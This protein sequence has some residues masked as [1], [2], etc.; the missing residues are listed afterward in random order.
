MAQL[1]H[2]TLTG[3]VRKEAQKSAVGQRNWAYSEVNLKQAKL[4]LDN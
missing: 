2:P 1:M 4:S 3:I